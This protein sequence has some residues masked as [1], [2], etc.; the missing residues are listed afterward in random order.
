MKTEKEYIKDLSEIRS[1]ME[2]SSKFLSLSGLSGILAGIYALLGAWVAY[3]LFYVHS[4]EM[5]LNTLSKQEVSGS[6]VD[7]ILLGILVLVL[8]VGTAA[9]FSRKKAAR[10]N[11]ALWN[12]VTR[13]MLTGMAIPLF[14]GGILILILISKGIMGLIAP[15][16][17]IFYGLALINA[18]KFTFNEI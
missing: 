6:V 1:M 14:S 11:E 18:S 15:L 9:L 16:T 8:S 2:R 3:R 12:P 13:R 5:A 17:L 10:N 7:L 4:D